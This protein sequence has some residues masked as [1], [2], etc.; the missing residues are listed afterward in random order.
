MRLFTENPRLLT[1]GRA[2]THITGK[3][4]SAAAK[5]EKSKVP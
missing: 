4:A 1:E 3:A 5:S 2:T